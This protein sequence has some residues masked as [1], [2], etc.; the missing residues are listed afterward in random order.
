MRA[1]LESREISNL[2]CWQ[3]LV[4][5]PPKQGKQEGS[6]VPNLCSAPFL[7]AVGG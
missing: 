4:S 2:H 7:G 5:G 1:G 3:R 6:C